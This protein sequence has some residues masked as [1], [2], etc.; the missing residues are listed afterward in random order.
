MGEIGPLIVLCTEQ[1]TAEELKALALFA[2]DPTC[3]L[4]AVV[5]AGGGIGELSGSRA[6]VIG[7]TK[8][9]AVGGSRSFRRWTR[10]PVLV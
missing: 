6:L 2:D 8:G 10:P 7:C 3:G 9:G 1:P 4:A 5:V